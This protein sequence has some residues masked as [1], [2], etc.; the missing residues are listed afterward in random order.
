M[1]LNEDTFSLWFPQ[2]LLTQ[3][4]IE[5]MTSIKE[6]ISPNIHI[7]RINLHPITIAHA[8]IK[9]SIIEDT[10]TNVWITMDPQYGHKVT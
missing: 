7:I 8:K 4:E 9:K 6:K 3:H 2:M 5:T 1:E 10:V